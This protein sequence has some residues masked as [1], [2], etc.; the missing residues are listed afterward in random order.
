M[1]TIETAKETERGIVDIE[2]LKKTNENLISTIDEVIKI[3]TEGRAKRQQA[4]AELG[5]METTLKKKLLE[6]KAD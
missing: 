2:T 1:A 4:E 3:Q 5:K 6:V